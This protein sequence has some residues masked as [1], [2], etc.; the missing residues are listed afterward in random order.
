[1]IHHEKSQEMFRGFVDFHNKIAKSGRNVF[2]L[3]Q[4]RVYQEG[5]D[6]FIVM[7]LLKRSGIHTLGYLMAEFTA[8][9]TFTSYSSIHCLILKLE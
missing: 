6:S 2:W 5:K 4:S 3:S 1:M 8:Q 9:R 7:E